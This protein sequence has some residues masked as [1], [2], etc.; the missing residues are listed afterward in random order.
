[1]IGALMAYAELRQP[2]MINSL[3][4]AGIS[5]PA[6][7]VGLVSVQTAEVLAGIVL[8]QVV[9]PG[10]PV[11]YA[12]AGSNADMASAMLSIGS[13]EDAVVS[14][15]N[16]QLCNYYQIPCRTS[17]ALTDSKLPDAQAGYEAA[18]TLMA[19]PISGGNF[20]LHAVGILDSYNTASYEQLIID[21]EIVGY[22]KRIMRGV[23]VNEETLAYEVIKEVGPR[24]NFLLEE[25]TLDHFRDEFYQPTLSTRQAYGVWEK[26]G[27]DAAQRANASWKKILEEYQESTLDPEVE[28]DLHRYM[29]KLFG[30]FQK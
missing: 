15:I 28:R 2:Q 6:T 21:N 27:R 7:L 1:M 17:G 30:Q 3:S 13:P 23:D 8:A 4:I 14:I 24:G 20:M 9:S 29:D 12:A 16:G 22:V 19:G 25:H 26:N 5:T 11:I 10:T 18:I